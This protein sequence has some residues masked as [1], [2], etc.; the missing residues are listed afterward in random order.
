MTR[1]LSIG[2]ILRNLTSFMIFR[3]GRRLFAFIP[4]LIF[5][6]YSSSDREYKQN[7]GVV[8]GFCEN[9]VKKRRTELEKYKDSSDL[10]TI[11]CQ[12]SLFGQNSVKSNSG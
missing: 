6:F 8:R 7:L 5:F 2:D 4:Y 12:Y 11:L 1:Y 9:I 10:L 3:T